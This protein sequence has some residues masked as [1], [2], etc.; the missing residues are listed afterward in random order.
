MM[1]EILTALVLTFTALPLIQ[2]AKPQKADYEYRTN[3]DPNGTGKFYLG[4]EIA[5]VMGHQGAAWLERSDRIE[6]ERPQDVIKNMGLS[7]TDNVADI[8]AGTGYFSFRIAPLVRQGKVYA[9]DIQPEMLRMIDERKA[10]SKLSNVVS[11]LGTEKDTK[12][13]ENTIDLAFMVDA[14]HEFS[15]PKEMMQ[16]IVRSLK[17][18]GRVLL[19]E[20]RGEDPDVPIKLVHKMTV[21][22][23]KL[24]MAAVGL[25]FKE[26]REFLP[27]QHFIVFEKA[28]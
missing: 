11:V 4:R 20:Y 22:Q 2:Q 25:K 27:Y 5:I 8:G 7:P 1:L 16:S 21:A 10:K 13:P 26:V 17:P 28:E 3:H 12:L 14:Y 15:Y 9:V 24:E 6:T 23:C 19:I 18:K